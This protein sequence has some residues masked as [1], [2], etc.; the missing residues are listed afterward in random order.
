VQVGDR[1]RIRPGEKVPVD[2]LVVEG[3]SAIDE[4]MITGESM[5]VERASGDKLIGGTLNTTGSLVMRAERV[6][7]DTVLAQIVAMVGQ[8]QRS[9]APIEKTVNRVA[10]F[11][12]PAVVLAAV[13]AFVGWSIWG[14]E[15]RLAHALVSAVSVLIIACPCARGL[16]T[17]MA[18]MVGTGRGAGE[19]VLF[20]DAEALETLRSADTLVVDKTGT[21]TEGKPSLVHIEPAAGFLPEEVLAVAAALERGSEH[22][23][24]AAIV[25]QAEERR[26][27]EWERG[28][29]G[30]GEKGESMPIR[31]EVV[32]FESLTGKGVRGTVA[33]RRVVVGNRGMMEEQRVDV[34]AVAARLAELRLAGQ[35]VVFVAVDGRLAGLL[36]IADAIKPTS[37]EAIVQ[38]HAE[39]MRVMMLTGDN[40]ITAQAVAR[41]MG[42]D[43]I[44]AEVLP[45]EKGEIVARLQR[46][47]HKVAMAGDGVNDAPALAQADVGI[48][49]GTGAD[50]AI[51]SAG[52][53]LVKGDLRGIV[54]ARRLS[55]ATSA[56]IRQNLLLAFLYNGLCIP[57]AAFGIITPMWASAAMS[58]SSL[59]V[60]VN[61]LRLRNARIQ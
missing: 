30:E 35:T 39:G 43:Q 21:I 56:A 49:M 25:R 61:S 2:G 1:L 18:F 37:R 27:H 42:L 4:S 6:G 7:G 26:M 32:G 51:E 28:R 23:L 29:G 44:E 31:P 52:V 22:P 20:R 41:E 17:P 3:H 36:G 12:V 58:L 60:I 34:S 8:A 38:L 9:R 15:P 57:L 46:E 53:T 14:S 59:S 19:G 11:F 45:R 24:A 55:R 47:G 48:A 50:V 10:Q 40:P 54:R 16:A 33:G 13:L 5:P